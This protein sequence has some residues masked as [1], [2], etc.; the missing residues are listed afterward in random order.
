MRYHAGRARISARELTRCTTP[1][2]GQVGQEPALSSPAREARGAHGAAGAKASGPAAPR[3]LSRL[4]LLRGGLKGRA[5]SVRP[6]GAIEESL[7]VDGCTRCGACIAACPERIL[8]KGR[9][10]FPEVDFARGG[11][12]FCGACADVCEPHAVIRPLTGARAWP[13]VAAFGEACLAERGVECRV[14]GERCESRAIRFRLR[15][16]RPAAPA[17]E[18]ARCSGCGACVAACPVLAVSMTI[19]EVVA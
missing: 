8:G 4:D 10:G 18:S 7:F 17:L 6:P 12:T 2:S 3:F 1:V 11:C 15:A 19:S 14:C 9:G 5:R 16:G 13:V